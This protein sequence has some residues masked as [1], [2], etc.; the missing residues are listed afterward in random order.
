[1]EQSKLWRS[2]VYSGIELLSATYTN[3]EF[4]STRRS[5]LNPLR[6]INGDG[7]LIFQM[8]HMCRISRLNHHKVSVGCSNEQCTTPYDTAQCEF[9]LHLTQYFCPLIAM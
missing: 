2:E 3:F 1:M 7:R 6:V 9:H 5:M 8:S 4:K